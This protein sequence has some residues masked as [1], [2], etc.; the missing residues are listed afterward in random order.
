ML[1]LQ[2]LESTP[3]D[4][5]KTENLPQLQMFSFTFDMNCNSFTV[6]NVLYDLLHRVNSYK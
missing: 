1:Q 3:Y 2:P 6:Y 4:K 5:I